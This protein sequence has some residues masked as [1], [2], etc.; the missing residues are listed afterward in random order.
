MVIAYFAS[1]V[2][3]YASGLYAFV[4][5][6]MGLYASRLYAPLCMGLY[7]SGLYASLCFCAFC[8]AYAF[9]TSCINPPLCFTPLVEW[10]FT[11]PGLTPL[12][13]WGFTHLRIPRSTYL[14][15]FDMLCL[16]VSRCAG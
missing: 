3:L 12:V 2:G 14:L 6:C 11:P 9:A 16:C 15:P 8:F 13:V 7:A 1:Y 4:S 5:V 10:G